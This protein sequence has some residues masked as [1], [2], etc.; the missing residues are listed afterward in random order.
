MAAE[1]PLYTL[2]VNVLAL[3]FYGY[4]NQ[5]LDTEIIYLT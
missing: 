1:I 2:Y 4:Y 3:V 5:P